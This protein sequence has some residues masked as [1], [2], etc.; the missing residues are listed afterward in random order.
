[1][2]KTKGVGVEVPNMMDISCLLFFFSLKLYLEDICLFHGENEKN[3]H[4]WFCTYNTLGVSIL[5]FSKHYQN[6][7]INWISNAIIGDNVQAKINVLR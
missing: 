2:F 5:E 3:F 6:A 1:M 4:Q 7:S